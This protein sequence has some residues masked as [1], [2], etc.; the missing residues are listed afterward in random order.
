M[1]L[2][3]IAVLAAQQHDAVDP[4]I[5]AVG[6]PDQ[7]HTAQAAHGDDAHI[8]ADL[9]ALLRR[10]FQGGQG[11]VLAHEGDNT[12]LLL[13][14]FG[15]LDALDHVVAHGDGIVLE[16]DDPFRAGAHAGAAAA[17]TGDVRLG[18]ALH[19]LVQGAEGAV[20]GAAL[21]LGTALEEEVREGEIPAARVQRLALFNHLQGLHSLEA[22]A[23]GIHLGL[24]GVHR[25][26]HRA[27][28]EDGGPPGFVGEADEVA[29]REAVLQRGQVRALTVGQVQDARTLFGTGGLLLAVGSLALLQLLLGLFDGFLFACHGDH[30]GVRLVL[31]GPFFVEDFVRNA[32]GRHHT[33]G[34]DQHVRLDGDRLA[35]ER[36][37][38]VDAQAV[39]LLLHVDHFALGE[40]KALIILGGLVEE[41]VLARAA[42]ILVEHV[43]FGVRVHLAQLHGVLQAGAAADSAAVGQV[44]LVPAAGALDEGDG[45]RGL[46]V[47]GP[48]HFALQE[49]ALELHIGHHIGHA[50]AQVAQFLRVV[51]QPAGGLD[52]R[53]DLDRLRRAAILDVHL[54]LAGLTGDLEHAAGETH[55]D[56]AVFLDLADQLVDRGLDQLV[57]G[58]ARGEG[59]LGPGGPAT[60][61]VL[62]F[63]QHHLDPAG[64]CIQ[65]ATQPRHT[66]A[67]HQ[68]RALHLQRVGFGQREPLGLGGEH[69]QVVA[70]DPVLVLVVALLVQRPDHQLLHG[71]D[72]D[73]HRFAEVEMAGGV[74]PDAAVHNHDVVQ[75]LFRDVLLHHLQGGVRGHVLM[76]PVDRHLGF[77]FGDFFQGVHVEGFADLSVSGHI[78]PDFHFLVRH[79]YD[80]LA[81]STAFIAAPVA[82]CRVSATASGRTFVPTP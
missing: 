34:Q 35:Q 75:A 25:G 67:D 56:V 27:R 24:G 55:V 36:L 76:G 37:V 1:A 26:P 14:L 68:D 18:R 54:E 23:V 3:V 9:H 38:Q 79:L 74:G 47:A 64:A 5:Q 51:G 44:V 58:R 31:I 48:H 42:D 15:D 12:R 22:G 53:A 21:A 16:V 61:L 11:V 17:A 39:A 65:R 28:G 52:D 82:S 2:V 19:V 40:E 80:L 70:D 33:G 20:L 81:I 6:D 62:L 43:D 30:R 57:V 13:E 45:F 59:D 10:D 41:L 7:V 66:A 63:H 71:E 46:A 78:D 77:V 50:V 29:V 4:G 8:L 69:A 32:G 72:I 60:Q 49:H 73:H